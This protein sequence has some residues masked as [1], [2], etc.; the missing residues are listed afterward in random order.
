MEPTLLD[1]V[2]LSHLDFL[3]CGGAGRAN[4]AGQNDPMSTTLYIA[5]DRKVGGVQLN[6][7]G[8]HLARL[9]GNPASMGVF[10]S[11]LGG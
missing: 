2:R 5:L 8:V 3:E 7:D 4:I 1:D 11:K 6:R 9:F 10:C